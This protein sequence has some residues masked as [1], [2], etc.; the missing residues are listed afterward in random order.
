MTHFFSQNNKCS[1]G[2]ELQN[3]E[4]YHSFFVDKTNYQKL[5]DWITRNREQII[6]AITDR[7]SDRLLLPRLDARI[8][9]LAQ[10]LKRLEKK[11][12]LPHQRVSTRDLVAFGIKYPLA[13]R[14]YDYQYRSPRHSPVRDL[15]GGPCGVQEFIQISHSYEPRQYDVRFY[16]EREIDFA[17][18]QYNR[19]DRRNY[20]KEFRYDLIRLLPKGFPVRDHFEC[21]INA[22]LKI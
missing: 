18:W 9:D 16:L 17:V 8:D 6:T 3:S 21:I 2:V 20:F 5:S 19:I 4:S 10:Q 22:I 14:V 13:N 12:Q 15:D 7:N 1:C 11:Y